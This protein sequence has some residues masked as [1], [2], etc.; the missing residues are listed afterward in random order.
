SHLSAVSRAIAWKSQVSSAGPR[1]IVSWL[2]KHTG[3]LASLPGGVD[4]DTLPHFGEL[5]GV[6]RRNGRYLPLLVLGNC[7]AEDGTIWCAS[8]T[9]GRSEHPQADTLTFLADRE[10][11]DLEAVLN[12]VDHWTMRGN[13]DAMWWLGWWHE[14]TNIPASTWYYIAALRA[15]PQ[16][17]RWALRRIH[18]DTMAHV[19]GRGALCPGVPQPDMSF[20]GAIPEFEAWNQGYH[21]IGDDWREALTWAWTASAADYQT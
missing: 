14:G 1:S 10:Q 17:Y 8:W 21:V 3:T 6:R 15:D 20:V 7:V 11:P 12:R 5:W 19:A 4:P 13:A 9:T 2:H 16:R 18:S